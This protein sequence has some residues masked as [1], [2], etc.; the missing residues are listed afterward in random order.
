M[1]KN[2]SRLVT[3]LIAL[4][5]VTLLAGCKGSTTTAGPKGITYN[6]TKLEMD[7]PVEIDAKF[8]FDD[9]ILTVKL[10]S[11]TANVQI[12]RTTEP[13]KDIAGSYMELETL[14]EGQGLKNGDEVEVS[15][16]RGLVVVRVWGDGKDGIVKVA[17]KK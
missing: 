6:F 10:G 17:A 15:G 9:G 4:L 3:V 13:D 7:E 14:Y 11:G 8:S 1:K 16:M 5:L 2:R 12:C